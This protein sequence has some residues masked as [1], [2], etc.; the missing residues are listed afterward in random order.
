M[1]VG[2]FKD[3]WIFGFRAEVVGEFWNLSANN[4]IRTRNLNPNWALEYH[5]SIL[6][7][8]RNPY[9]IKVY[10]FFSLVS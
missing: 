9:E 10:T 4:G 3:S 1:G 2:S 6:F 5:T 8:E 7:S